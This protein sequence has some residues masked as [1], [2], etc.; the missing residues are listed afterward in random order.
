MHGRVN[1]FVIILAVGGMAAG[2]GCGQPADDN[3]RQTQEGELVLGRAEVADTVARA[4]APGTRPLLLTG[5]N[6][7]VRLDGT[8]ADIA[9]LTFV[10]RGRGRDEGAARDVLGNIE[11]V[12][13][14]NA[15]RYEYVMRS[16]TPERSAVD[17]RGTVPRSTALRI[18]FESGAVALSGVEGPID[19]AHQN[20]NVQIDGAG[21][22]VHVDIRNGSIRVGLRT[23][24]P[25][26]RAELQ[27]ANGDVVVAV[28]EG[29][30]ARVTAATQAGSINTPGLTFTSQRLEPQG[31]GA[32]FEA[33]LG[34]GNATID[35]RTE[36]GSITVQRRT[37]VLVPADSMAIEPVD[38]TAAPSNPRLPAPA[39]TAAPTDTAMAVPDPGRAP[40][41]TAAG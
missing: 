36:N 10:E 20:G 6:G 27:T 29:V 1:R 40:T 21:A 35:L 31:A 16:D 38:T 33:Q 39:D 28:P 32:R 8:D 3:V 13:R 18:G 7:T 15:E 37:E 26:A 11:L 2:L 4:V 34:A 19:V 22:S 30:S 12:E 17:V 24:P 14:G 5:F 9:R 23:L 41:D 25:G